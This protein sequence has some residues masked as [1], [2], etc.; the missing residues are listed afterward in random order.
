MELLLED[1]LLVFAIISAALSQVQYSIIF[2]LQHKMHWAGT[3]FIVL[4]FGI[5]VIT[6]VFFHSM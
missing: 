3:S 1:I 5:S 2:G 6:R 4:G